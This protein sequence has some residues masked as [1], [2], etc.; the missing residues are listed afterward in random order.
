MNKI[1]FISIR[2]GL[3]LVSSAYAAT[4]YV[5][6]TGSD[7]N[8]GTQSLPWKTIAKAESMMVAGDTVIV[9]SGYYNERVTISGT[10]GQYMEPITFIGQD[11]R[12]NGFVIKSNY[13]AVEGFTINNVPSYGIDVQG[14]HSIVQ[15]NSISNTSSECIR[16]G[17]HGGNWLDIYSAGQYTIVKNNV[18]TR[19]H[20][21]GIIT[22]GRNNTIDGNDISHSWSASGDANGIEFFGS[23]HT[24]SN[25]VIHDIYLNDAP[26][27]H[28][29]CFQSYGS[30]YNILFESN[31]CLLTTGDEFQGL[32]LEQLSNPSDLHSPVENITF[33]YNIW[34]FSRPGITYSPGI[35]S[36]AKTASGQKQI[37]NI[38]IDHNTFVRDSV[39][40]WT[41]WFENNSNIIIT[42]NIF[43]NGVSGKS[44]DNQ[45][46]IAGHIVRLFT[47]LNEITANHN[48]VFRDDGVILTATGSTNGVPKGV[49]DV[50]NVNPMFE[51]YLENDFRPLSTLMNGSINPV[52]NGGVDGT[53]IGALPCIDSVQFS[54]ADLN[55]N[56][57][58]DLGEISEYVGLWLNDKVKLAD[59]SGAVSTWMGGC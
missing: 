7:T 49:G 56:G 52:C 25:N 17:T 55:Q 51:N 46:Y 4:Y 45:D 44:P 54:P 6:I 43:Y 9:L 40:Q 1:F 31:R 13:I 48:S 14:N 11:A 53:Y 3:L 28:L 57:C 8:P 16:V 19:C 50:W 39:G 29:D 20:T 38:L 33:K 59:V 15:N 23:G 27:A 36:V 32:M 2:F 42:N 58:I 5:S 12:M 10:N 24:I 47:P 41:I 34:R 30:V 22:F 26:S 18:L 21:D 37:K 35:T